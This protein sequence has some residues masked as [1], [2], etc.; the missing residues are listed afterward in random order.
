MKPLLVVLVACLA[1]GAS[2]DA[3]ADVVNGIDILSKSYTIHSEWMYRWQGN[4]TYFKGTN[5][6]SSA[7][8]SPISFAM[9]SN[10]PGAVAI[11]TSI[12]GFS[13]HNYAYAHQAGINPL[14]ASTATNDQAIWQFKPVG[15]T[16]DV[17]LKIHEFNMLDLYADT[18]ISLQDVT[19]STT[20]LSIDTRYERTHP[21]HPPTYCDGWGPC[22]IDKTEVFAVNPNH[23]YQFRISAWSAVYDGDEAAQSVT[24]TLTSVP[25]PSPL[26]LLWIGLCGL[27]G[28][29]CVKQGR[30][31]SA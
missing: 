26:W 30:R 20:L 15:T 31:I 2:I 5:D 21:E 22:T 8:G 19:D 10:P 25:E 16:L 24:V 4:P 29:I 18:V 12:S 23:I 17:G 13:F 14:L 1:V 6:Q 27:Y 3:R 28:G 11:S 7:D 9:D